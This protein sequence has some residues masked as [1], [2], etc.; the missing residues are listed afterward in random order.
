V[1]P[2]VRGDVEA[3]HRVERHGAIA[4][5]APWLALHQAHAGKKFHPKV[6]EAYRDVLLQEEVKAA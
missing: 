5:Q 4:L 3:L 1:I 6:A 2:A